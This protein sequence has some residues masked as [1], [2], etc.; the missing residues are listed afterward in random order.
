MGTSFIGLFGRVGVYGGDA[1]EIRNLGLIDPNVEGGTG[2][3]IG[4]LLGG[5]SNGIITD[6]YSHG[7]SVS[8]DQNIGGLVGYTNDGMMSQCY[9]T[10]SVSGNRNVGGMIGANAVHV[11]NSYS[12][13]IVTGNSY[14]GGLVGLAGEGGWV[15]NSFWDV[16]TSGQEGGQGGLGKTTREMQTESTFTDAGWDFVEVWGIGDGQ[17]YPYLRKHIAGDL[18][19]DGIVDGRDFAIFAAHWLEEA[20]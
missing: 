16:N 12:A 8:G 2:D 17:T 14:V 6:C 11:S 20:N 18:N 15:T 3:H 19:H 5:L 13:G 7:G 9:A 1:G 4:S 10:T